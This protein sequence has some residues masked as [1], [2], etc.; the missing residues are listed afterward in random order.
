MEQ[1]CNSNHKSIRVEVEVRTGVTVREA[2]T[3]GRDKIT[4]QIAETEFSTDKIEVGLG[5]NQD[6]KRIIREVIFAEM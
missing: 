4:D 3:M 6:M 5:M 1:I 2:T